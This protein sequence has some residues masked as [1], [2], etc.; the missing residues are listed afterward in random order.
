MKKIKTMLRSLL[1][2]LLLAL[3]V[4]PTAQAIDFGLGQHL[5]AALGHDLDDFVMYARVYR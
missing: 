3:A 5:E 4:M 1:P 2:V